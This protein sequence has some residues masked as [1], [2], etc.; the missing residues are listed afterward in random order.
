M[1]K[2]FDNFKTLAFLFMTGLL[3]VGC[4]SDDDM[5]PTGEGESI[6]PYNSSDHVYG[7]LA[8]R[9]VGTW[10][11]VIDPSTGAHN[12]VSETETPFEGTSARIGG[13]ELTSFERNERLFVSRSDDSKLKVQDLE[14]FNITEIDLTDTSLNKTVSFPQLLQ[15]GSDQNELYLMD[16]DYSLWKINLE[17]KMVNKIYDRI[18]VSNGTYISNLFY[19]ASTGHFLGMTNTDAINDYRGDNL[20]LFDTAL[21]D[22]TSIISTKSIS[23]GF[24]FV[25][26]PIDKNNIYF[27]QT[28]QD[29]KGFRLMKIAINGNELDVSEISTTDLSI[30]NLSPY[31]QTIHTASNTYIL[32]GGSND[33]EAPTNTLY[34]IN[35]NTGEL[36]HEV[37]IEETGFL[38][39]LAGE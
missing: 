17:S 4:S 27:I 31:L 30:D 16:T 28:S 8:V 39:N 15:F 1:K 25:Q 38:L 10:E 12:K 22:S 35:I 11:I 21:P 29:D 5:P 2:Y 23:K 6:L 33:I 9:D 24:G 7:T 32:R 18:P 36:I 37:E 34:S 14:T 26:H 3:L 19:V 20:F 13:L